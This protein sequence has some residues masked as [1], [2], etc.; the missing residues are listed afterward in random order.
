MQ[1]SLL[2]PGSG[3]PPT[4]R[5]TGYSTYA[6]PPRPRGLPIL[7]GILAVL[8]G[9]VGIIVLLAGLLVILAYYHVIA[10]SYVLVEGTLFGSVV[11]FGA[12]FFILGMIMA[13][14][15]RG[16]W[17]QE[18]WALNTLGLVVILELVGG[19]LDYAAGD[20]PAIYLI[21]VFALLLVYLIAVRH[22]FS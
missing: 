5:Q 18:S 8:I 13:A 15:A 10:A 2:F 22:H 16:L 6:P 7:V 17:D 19:I 4:S 14:V 3:V 11:I 1:A 9:I 21:I 12:Y 20:T